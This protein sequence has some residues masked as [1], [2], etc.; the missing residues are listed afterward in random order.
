MY[1]TGAFWPGYP[2]RTPTAATWPVVLAGEQ[3]DQKLAALGCH[4]SQVGPLLYEL[5]PERYRRLASFEAYRAANH[6]ADRML[7]LGP[8]CAA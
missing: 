5:R 8:P 6:A 1:R 7:N 4:E 3:L 2:H